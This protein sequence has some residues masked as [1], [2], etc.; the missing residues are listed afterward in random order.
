MNRNWWLF[1]HLIGVLAFLAVHGV[2]MTVLIR[3]REERN[4]ERIRE[5]LQLSGQTVV[6]MYLSLALLL[7]GGVGGAVQQSL[8][9]GAF[10]A[11]FVLISLYIL[12]GV[13]IIMFG[14]AR[15]YYRR[16]K[17]SLDLRPSGAP[18]VS[19][20]DLDARLRSPVPVAVAVLG[21]GAL[22]S[23]LWLMI[24]KPI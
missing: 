23:I 22:V 24:W 21:T 3:L 14:M 20:A 16:I 9:K 19:D 5:L 15:P 11:K 4:R 6:P 12:V 7:A 18:R 1:I 2:S 13:T 10:R 8:F 17:E